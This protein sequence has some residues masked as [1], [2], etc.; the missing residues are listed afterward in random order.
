MAT[1]ELIKKHKT[2]PFL[3]K[4]TPDAPEW[5]QIKKATEWTHSLNP[6]TEERDYISDE[7][8]T[9]ELTQYKPSM[10][11]AVTTICGE[12]DFE[13]FYDL[14]KNKLVGEDAK[15]EY[16]IV[17]VFDSVTSGGTD[18]YYAYKT[19]ATITVDEFNSVSSTITVSIYENGTPTRGY[20][21]L[22]DGSPS[23]TAGDMPEEDGG[24]AGAGGGG[25]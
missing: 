3:N 22:V 14:Y 15:K 8:P 2:L 17:Y 20:V 12:A 11:L 5:V 1:T 23:F 7:Q 4:G 19:E 13:L 18:Y 9:T 16:L 6:E 10:S 21:T 25:G 24:G